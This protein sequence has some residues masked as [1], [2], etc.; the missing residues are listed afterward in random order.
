MASA[1]GAILSRRRFFTLFGPTRGLSKGRSGF[2]GCFTLMSRYKSASMDTRTSSP[3][4]TLQQ[5]K[6]QSA[7]IILLLTTLR[8]TWMERN[9]CQS[10]DG[11]ALRTARWH[12]GTTTQEPFPPF[13][14]ETSVTH[15]TCLQEGLRD[16]HSRASNTEQPWNL[17]A[18]VHFDRPN[19]VGATHPDRRFLQEAE[20]NFQQFSP[21]GAASSQP[22]P[23]VSQVAAVA[24]WGL[25]RSSNCCTVVN[26]M[27]V[28][29][30]LQSRRKCSRDFGPVSPFQNAVVFL[31]LALL[32][33]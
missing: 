27:V 6:Q 20:G 11:R 12:N 4:S 18:M 14:V 29:C 32:T 24:Y 31:I 10:R 21:S 30:S 8:F 1:R 2:L 17:D 3:Q 25:K 22:Q 5:H 15:R 26:S 19:D 28:I 16:D 7:S 33:S 13:H 23:P 9:E